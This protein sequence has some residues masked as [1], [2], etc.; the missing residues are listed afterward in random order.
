[1]LSYLS[2]AGAQ[3]EIPTLRLILTKPADIEAR[4]RRLLARLQGRVAADLELAPGQASVGG[5]AFADLRLPS[6]E[7]RVRPRGARGTEIL[8][9]L[10]QGEPAV[11]A[12]IKDDSLGFDLR[13]VPDD[14]VESLALALERAL[15][16]RGEGA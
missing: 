6:Y 4:A 9:R 7:V 12:R 15:A 16:A 11:V 8:A 5:G 10:R 3:H 13:C 14:E 2:R 1:L